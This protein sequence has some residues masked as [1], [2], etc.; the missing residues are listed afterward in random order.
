MNDLDLCINPVEDY[1]A[2]ML[3]KFGENSPDLLEKMPSRWQ[4]NAKIIAG[5]G[6]VSMFALSSECGTATGEPRPSNAMHNLW[7]TH[8]SY[9]GYSESELLLRIHT[10]GGGGSAYMVH[11]TEYEAFAIIRARLETAGLI[12]DAPPPERT[13][14]DIAPI[15]IG[16]TVSGLAERHVRRNFEYIELDLYDVQKN[17]GVLNVS[18]LGGGR[19]FLLHERDLGRCIEGLFAEQAGLIVGAFYNPGAHIDSGRDWCDEEGRW[20]L[21]RPSNRNAE[22]LRPALVR[23]LLNQADEFIVRL[24]SEGILERQPDINV[25]INDTPYIFGEYPIIINNQKMVP[26]IELFEALEMEAVEDVNEWRRA[27]TASKD[28]VERIWIS[29][30]GGIMVNGEWPPLDD[31]PV[32]KYNYT[33]LVPLQ[34][35]ADFI[36]ATIDWNEETRTIKI[37]Y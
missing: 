5:L 34:F 10:G 23:Q 26:A 24:Q 20:I 30:G 7:Y 4:K 1:K 12:F 11:L 21:R 14:L 35:I 17:V 8:G 27:I 37:T 31:V 6:L 29:S 32:M 19:E 18:W 9:S 2:P 13:R 33:I 36:G 28:G 22:E 3:P 16:D 15:Q 25:I